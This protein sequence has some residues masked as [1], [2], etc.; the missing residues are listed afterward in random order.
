MIPGS[1]INTLVSAIAAQS[2]SRIWASSFNTIAGTTATAASGFERVR[3]RIPFV[4]PFDTDEIFFSYTGTSQAGNIGNDY[5]VDSLSLERAASTNFRAVNFDGSNRNKTITNGVQEVVTSIKASAFG[6]VKFTKNE[7]YYIRQE[8]SVAAAGLKLPQSMYN[9]DSINGI[10]DSPVSIGLALSTTAVAGAVDAVGNMTFTSGWSNFTNPMMPLVSAVPL[11]SGKAVTIFGDSLVHQASYSQKENGYVSAFHRGCV[12]AD[13]VNNPIGC[14]L[15]AASGSTY[16]LVLGKNW[17]TYWCKYAKNTVDE[18]G[19][20]YFAAN[21]SAYP[22][23]FVND[24]VAFWQQVRDAGCTRILRVAFPPRT[25]T[26]DGTVP[27]NT[28]WQAGGSARQAIDWMYTPNVG[29]P[30]GVTV[31]PISID[32]VRQSADR[33]TDNYYKW[34]GATA[35]T[36]G[37]YTLEGTHYTTVGCQQAAIDMRVNYS[38]NLV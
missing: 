32:S 24:C 9:Y 5:S 23:A 31:I 10:F 30:Y 26:T 4:L 7:I 12:D 27:F 37:T 29:T 2:G 38:T 33:A 18:H 13:L 16:S 15:I 19:T 25:S 20:N 6:L 17:L 3:A 28:A 21:S 8:Y 1:T 22:T 35:G 34:S 11:T 36:L 14:L